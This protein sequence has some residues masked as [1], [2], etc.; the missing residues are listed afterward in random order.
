MSNF[1]SQCAHLFQHVPEHERDHVMR[2]IIEFVTGKSLSTLIVQKI[3]LTAEQQEHAL[4]IMRDYLYEHKPLAYSFGTAEFLDCTLAIRPPVLIPRPETEEWVACLIELLVPYADKPLRLV[5]IGTGS[6][7]IALALAKRFP[8]FTVIAVDRAEHALALAQENAVKNNIVNI[9]FIQSDLLT[10]VATVDMVIS[11]PPYISPADYAL[12]DPSVRYWEDKDALTAA[13]D[14]YVIIERIVQQAQQKTTHAY[15]ELPSIV[16]EIGYNQYT[17][18]VQRFY[19]QYSSI[20][21]HKDFCGKDR[22]M[23]F[24]K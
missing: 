12:L 4:R 8:Q 3:E 9:Q 19:T 5:D 11:N 2:S 21:C 20:I 6:G 16:M 14:G 17:G 15:P 7:C 1:L 18:V 10:A 13:D 22:V 23:Y 24:Y